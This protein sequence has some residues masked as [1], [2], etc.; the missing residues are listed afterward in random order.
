MSRAR[1]Y[2][3]W[4]RVYVTDVKCSKRSFRNWIQN[5]LVNKK[6]CNKKTK[7][8]TIYYKYFSGG[9]TVAQW[10]DTM[11]RVMQMSLPW[12]L[13]RDRLAPP[14]S[15]DEP[16]IVNYLLTLELLETDVIVSVDS[17]KILKKFYIILKKKKKK[18]PFSDR[19]S[20][21]F[22]KCHRCAVQK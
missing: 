9:V 6:C 13:M 5:T 16:N 18:L 19:G 8:I 4:V 14:F 11:E 15:P 10:S 3:N 21:G 12:R 17:W 22:Y 1:R 2:V 7:S 20:R